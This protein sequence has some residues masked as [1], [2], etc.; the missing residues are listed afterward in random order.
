[1]ILSFNRV[2]GPDDRRAFTRPRLTPSHLNKK[3]LMLPGKPN[4]K[5][6][7]LMPAF[8]EIHIRFNCELI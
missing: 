6:G 1:M 2:L 3:A 4:Q 7:W 8:A 5:Q